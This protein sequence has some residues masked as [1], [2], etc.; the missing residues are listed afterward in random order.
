M[1]TS[2]YKHCN[3]LCSKVEC[4]AHVCGDNDKHEHFTYKQKFMCRNQST[5]NLLEARL[6]SIV[7]NWSSQ[8]G[9]HF[10]TSSQLTRSN[11]PTFT[12]THQLLPTLFSP[13]LDAQ[14]RD[15]NT[16]EAAQSEL[17]GNWQLLH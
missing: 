9:A 3:L 13:D 11:T 15:L 8:I 14:L 10:P 16:L 17:D 6:L 7:V 5:F 2:F 1:I 4:T 12:I